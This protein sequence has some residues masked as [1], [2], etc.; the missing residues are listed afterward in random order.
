MAAAGVT[1]KRPTLETELGLGVTL[2]VTWKRPMVAGC[3]GTEVSPS[4]ESPLQT[5][6]ESEE[7]RW[8]VFSGLEKEEDEE[9]EEEEVE[10][11]RGVLGLD[12][13]VRVGC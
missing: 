4:T 11:D 1:E 8:R 6:L 3:V 7:E 5:P 13:G 9:E 12:G 10:K 2:A